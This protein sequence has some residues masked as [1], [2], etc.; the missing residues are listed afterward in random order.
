MVVKYI[1]CVL[2]RKLNNHIHTL[3]SKLKII[4]FHNN[5]LYHHVP[6]ECLHYSNFLNEIKPNPYKYVNFIATLY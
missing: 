4:S 1:V 3:N 5:F 2:R 6:N